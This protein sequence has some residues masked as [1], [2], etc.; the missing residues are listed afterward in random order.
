MPREGRA[1]I[2]FSCDPKI[3][4]RALRIARRSGRA[5]LGSVCRMALKSYLDDQEYNLQIIQ[6]VHKTKI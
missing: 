4:E 3:K 1:Y 5:S 6:Q 2:G